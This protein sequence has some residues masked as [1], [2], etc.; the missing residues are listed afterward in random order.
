MT[1]PVILLVFFAQL[2]W[3]MAVSIVQVSLWAV[4]GGVYVARELGAA[5]AAEVRQL[6][7]LAHERGWW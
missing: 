1:L 6:D 3:V 7:R 2:V 5:L 4:Q